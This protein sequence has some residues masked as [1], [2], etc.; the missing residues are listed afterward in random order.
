MHDK[1][2]REVVEGFKM[3]ILNGKTSARMCAVVC[4]P[5]QGYLSFMGVET[6]LIEGDFGEINHVWLELEDGRIID[7]T[8]DQFFIIWGINKMPPVY[9]GVKPDFYPET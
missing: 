4:Y 9:I 7:P 8:A 1:E 5:L 6:K 2:L 3:G